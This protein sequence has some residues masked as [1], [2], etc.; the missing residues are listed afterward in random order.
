MVFGSFAHS[1]GLKAKK[2]CSK[3]LESTQ[4]LNKNDIICA[5]GLYNSISLAW[6]M[7]SD[8]YFNL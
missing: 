6:C 5:G 8:T 7:L 1:F 4:N 2:A 3:S